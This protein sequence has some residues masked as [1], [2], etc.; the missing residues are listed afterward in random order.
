MTGLLNK[1]GIIHKVATD[2]HPQTNGQPRCPT[3]RSS[4]YSRRLLSLIEGDWS[5]R[6]GDAIWAYRTSYKTPIGMSSFHLDYE[7]ACHLPVEVEHKAYWAVREC[8]SGLGGAGIERKLQLE[9]LECLRLEAYENS[10]LYKEKVKA[11][12]DRNIKRREFRAGIK[13]FFTTPG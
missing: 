5:S 11:V 1:D 4:T 2:Y 3:E 8:N 12:H 6:L 13:P 9:E 7:K 10:R